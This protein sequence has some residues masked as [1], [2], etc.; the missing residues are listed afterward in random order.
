MIR[1]FAFRVLIWLAFGAGCAGKADPCP[2]SPCPPA[3]E[4]QDYPLGAEVRLGDQLF[5]C[6]RLPAD[7]CLAQFRPADLSGAWSY[8]GPVE[9]CKTNP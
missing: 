7:G 9:N 8:I 1:R 5:I 6:T 2:S 4:A 3:W